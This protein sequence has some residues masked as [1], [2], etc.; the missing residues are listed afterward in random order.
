MKDTIMKELELF[1]NSEVEEVTRILNNPFS[2][3]VPEEVVNS[4]ISRC[5]GVTV[6]VQRLGISYE[7]VNDLYESVRDK[8][9]NLK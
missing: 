4:S 3:V 1:Y 2:W 5:L 6:F 9:D 8:L 7:E